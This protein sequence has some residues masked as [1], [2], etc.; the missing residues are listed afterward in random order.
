MN[1]S[2]PCVRRTAHVEARGVGERHAGL[3]QRARRAL[4][5]DPLELGELHAVVDAEHLARLARDEGRTGTFCL[6]AMAMTSVR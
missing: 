4:A 1:T 5:P 2:L 6:T 3:E